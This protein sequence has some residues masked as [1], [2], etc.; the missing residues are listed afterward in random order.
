MHNTRL[1]AHR[2][3]TRA[4][5]WICTT[6]AVLVA[7]A[8]AGCQRHPDVD[9]FASARDKQDA[10]QVI[11]LLRSHHYD[12]LIDR[13]QPSLRTPGLGATFERMAMVFPAGEPRSRKLVG[14]YAST[15]IVAGKGTVHTHLLTYEFGFP[16][17]VWVLAAVTQR[18]S[19]NSDVIT[20]FRVRRLNDSIEHLNRFALAGKGALAYLL[21]VAALA[22]PL[23]IVYALVR[24]V[25]TPLR[26]RKWPWV[27]FILFGLGSFSLDWSTGQWSIHM[28]SLQLLGAAIARIGYGP[29][30]L[31][32]SVPL[33]AIVF[34]LRRRHLA[35]AST[36]TVPGAADAGAET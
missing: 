14:A 34:L 8:I 2:R 22:V 30:I 25:R 9:A 13:M 26:G 5:R 18:R 16:D 32:V 6:M 35:A 11:Q 7:V 23:L 17:H 29:W 3:R 21:L 12:A 10:L 19:G 33:G 4:L 27:L 24:C 1:R 15:S 36:A 31:S 28:V 20:G